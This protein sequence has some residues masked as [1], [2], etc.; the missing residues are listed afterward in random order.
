LSSLEDL[1]LCPCIG[2]VPTD[3][4][5]CYSPNDLAWT[6]ICD[7]DQS[8][9]EGT[10]L[11]PLLAAQ[12]GA[13]GAT[14]TDP[15]RPPL[16]ELPLS[17]LPASYAAVEDTSVPVIASVSA[18]RDALVERITTSRPSSPSGRLRQP[19]RAPRQRLELPYFVDWRGC[20]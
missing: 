13:G 12:H 17:R 1:V 19:G 15:P 4:A 8:S 5:A 18:S 14:E 2:A 11:G 9:G 6:G 3:N 10:G 20:P 7:G 16:E